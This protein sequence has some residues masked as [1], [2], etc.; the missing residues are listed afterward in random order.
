MMEMDSA[1][2]RKHG[3][4]AKRS[5]DVPMISMVHILADGKIYWCKGAFAEQHHHSR[6]G[7]NCHRPQLICIGNEDGTQLE[8]VMTGGMDNPVEVALIPEGE[9]F[10]TNTFLQHPSEGRRDG[11]PTPSTEAY[12]LK[13][14]VYKVIP[15]QVI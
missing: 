1:K 6:T 2:R 8:I 15:E 14:D 12:L 9:K 4:M 13:H 10:F 11:M 7:K 5:L 3:L